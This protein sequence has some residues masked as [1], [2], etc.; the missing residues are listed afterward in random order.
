MQSA[1][2]PTPKPT[3]SATFSRSKL[4]SKHQNGFDRKN[5]L[6]ESRNYI[7]TPKRS[8]GRP[9][10]AVTEAHT[11]APAP[12]RR[13]RPPKSDKPTAPTSAAEPVARRESGRIAK[14]A[15]TTEDKS[16]GNTANKPAK[17]GPGR[18]PTKQASK[19]DAPTPKPGRGRPKKNATPV[20]KVVRED[21]RKSE[22]K[23]VGRPK[24]VTTEDIL[25]TD[26]PAKRGPGRPPKSSYT[27]ADASEKDDKSATD[28]PKRGRPPKATTT[29]P[30]TS[31]AAVAKPVAGKRGR[32]TK[33]AT[34]AAV[35]TT[36]KKEK[37]AAPAKSTTGRG[38]GRPPKA[39][40]K[41]TAAPK[42]TATPKEKVEKKT[43]TATEDENAP[44]YWLLKAEP[45]SRI[46]NGKDVKFSI[47]DL[48]DVKEPEAWDGMYPLHNT[49]L[50][51]KS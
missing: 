14:L 41:T 32:P 21:E 35:T 25:K 12:K 1:L 40:S 28:A 20:A 38:P 17:R 39:E 44:H 48:K 36:P 46:E 37:E 10:K 22:K 30:A 24:K 6:T 49:S 33:T 19:E 4:S 45:E 16:E 11:E 34:A 18:P 29:S 42:T 13:G 8:V 50:P 15:E 2:V 23:T 47:D 26:A 3:V 27:K 5:V 9:R 51:C 31:K 43:E 7:E